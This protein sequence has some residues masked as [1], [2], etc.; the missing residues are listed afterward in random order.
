M[1]FSVTGTFVAENLNVGANLNVA[2]IAA[3]PVAFAFPPG[4]RYDF[5]VHNFRGS[6]GSEA[7]YG[8]N[9]VGPAFEFDGETFISIASGMPDDRP[10]LVEAHKNHLFLAFPK[11]SL[12]HSALG[13]PLSFEAEVGAAE[14]GLGHEI[15]NLVPNAN[16]AMFITTVSSIAVLTGNDSSDWVLEGIGDEDVGAK[17]YTAQR[18]GQIVYMDNRGLRSAASTDTYGNFRLATYTSLINKT[19][20]AKRKA[21]VQ[22]V[23]S[24]VVKSKDQYLLFFSD[25]T[26]LSL[27]FGTKKPEAMLGKYPFVVSAIHSAEVDGEERVWVGAADGFVY[28]LNR[29]RSFD[30][31]AIFAYVALPYAHQGGPRTMKRYHGIELE[32][33]ADFGTTLGIVAQFNYANGWQPNADSL[34]E[35]VARAETGGNPIV[36]PDWPDFTWYGPENGQVHGWLK[37]S[38]VNMG[39]ILVT[40]SALIESP[41]VEGATVLFSPRGVKR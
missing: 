31:A 26:F 18:I 2:T 15:T 25:G 7:A 10:F 23:G 32:M 4:G 16:A 19:L 1:L 33:Q 30:G 12:Q 17:A 20:D 40:N 27:Y 24:I 9:G 11:G 39:A 8:A 13:E 38:G 6:V 21:K 41:I 36:S 34:L 29:G 14:L 22:P 37:G 28:E 5:E 3:A 35:T